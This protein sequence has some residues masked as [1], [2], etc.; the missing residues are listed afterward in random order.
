[1]QAWRGIAPQ[2]LLSGSG[3]LFTLHGD[4]DIVYH[5]HCP[6]SALVGLVERIPG[7]LLVPIHLALTLHVTASARPAVVVNLDDEVGFH[8]CVLSR[9]WPAASCGVRRRGQEWP[10]DQRRIAARSHRAAP[11]PAT[12]PP[13]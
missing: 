8:A 9:A 12:P 13:G 6:L 4:L 7:I 11:A 1:M 10:S 3:V 2:R 5:V